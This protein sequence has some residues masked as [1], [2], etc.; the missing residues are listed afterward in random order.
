[1][2]RTCLN[3]IYELAKKDKRI[4]FFGSDLGAGTL[5]QFKQEMPERFFMEGIA[6]AN[7][8]G[9]MS[10]LAM[11]DKIPY[12]NAI[13]VFLTRRCY[14]QILLDACMQNLKI[15]LVG[16]GGGLVYAPLGPTHLAFDDIALMRAIPNMTIVAPCDAEEMKRLM[17]QT[18]DYDG[19]MYIRL[20]KGGDPIVSRPENPFE[21]GRAIYMCEGDDALIV[22]TGITLKEGLQ[23]VNMLKQ[24]GQSA[25]VLH[26]HTIKPL[27]T[28]MLL[29]RA[30]KVKVVVTVEE[31]YECGG[32]GSAVAEVLAE[33]DFSVRFKRLAIPAVYPN[34]YGS[35]DL[36]MEHYGIMASG[37]ASKVMSLIK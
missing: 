17:P 25:G 20:A 35:Q 37:I 7:I 9:M 23:A 24:E 30:E 21:I 8:I 18:V 32:L 12:L 19:P 15:R 6:E 29:K 26:M 4:V 27:D 2:R 3:Q 22:T 11:N 1:M 33:A 13:A 28:A 5:E 36:Q 34:L 14:E 10:G 16:N 31:H